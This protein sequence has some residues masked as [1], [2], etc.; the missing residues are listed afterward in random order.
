MSGAAPERCAV[1]AGARAEGHPAGGRIRR[2]RPYSGR[3]W[4]EMKA[5]GG[6]VCEQAPDL[7]GRSQKIYLDVEEL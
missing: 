4:G 7:T 2:R 6:R 5:L 3:K 1:H